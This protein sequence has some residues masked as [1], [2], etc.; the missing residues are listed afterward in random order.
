M[1]SVLKLINLV[2][3]N[4]GQAQMMVLTKIPEGIRNQ[5][6]H[7][8]SFADIKRWLMGWY[9]TDNSLLAGVACI[10]KKVTKTECMV[11]FFDDVLPKILK[12]QGLVNNYSALS[13]VE[14]EAVCQGIYS[15]EVVDR[16]GGLLPARVMDQVLRDQED[17]MASP[18][19]NNYFGW[20]KYKQQYKLIVRRCLAMEKNRSMYET[21]EEGTKKEDIEGETDS[22]RME[23]LI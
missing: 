8:T 7:L 21:M 5:C 16:I 15:K 12:I 20:K 9:G 4:D 10:L 22:A 3:I 17:H 6:E 2:K 19:T 11:T 13:G 23:V 14:E 1:S 18:L